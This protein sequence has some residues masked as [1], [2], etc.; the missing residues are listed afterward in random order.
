MLICRPRLILC[1][2]AVLSLTC[3][4]EAQDS[5]QDSAKA[6]PATPDLGEITNGI[7]KNPFFGFS[8]RLAYGWV[9]RTDEMREASAD[10]SR[11]TVLLSVFE[12]PPQAAGSSVNAAVVIAAE[13][14]SSYPGLKNAAQY[15]G[16]I[17][18]VT[19][20]KGLKPVNDPYEFPVDGKPIV[21]RDFVKQA[22]NVGMH[23]ST[24]AMLMRGYVL[25]FTF[26]GTSD[27]EVQQLLEWL[28]F[29]TP[30]KHSRNSAEPSK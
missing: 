12:R 30:V 8:Y 5:K 17:S 19:E 27:D 6:T 7:Y 2:I 15:F 14:I 1:A 25:S 18:E 4:L 28:K 9:D 21:R 13:S 23:Q 16:P 11:S 22:S 10:P 20:A 3:V 24:L 29:G 26:I